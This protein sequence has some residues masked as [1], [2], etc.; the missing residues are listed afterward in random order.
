MPEHQ[1]PEPRPEAAARDVPK[2]EHGQH[3]LALLLRYAVDR[4]SEEAVQILFAEN[5]VNIRSR[6]V[7]H[8]MGKARMKWLREKGFDLDG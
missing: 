3:H 2:V 8:N 4:R 7:V 1:L 5:P 6:H